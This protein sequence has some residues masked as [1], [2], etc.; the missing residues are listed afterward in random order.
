MHSLLL[1]LFEAAFEITSATRAWIEKSKRSLSSFLASIRLILNRTRKE[2]G[3]AVDYP[4]D[5]PSPD[6]DG[7]SIRSCSY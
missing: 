1:T 5:A 6:L 4:I 7:R 2:G 3:L